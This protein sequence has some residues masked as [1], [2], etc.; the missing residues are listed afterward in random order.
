MPVLRN[1]IL[2][3]F[4]LRDLIFSISNPSTTPN[5][6]SIKY[7]AQIIGFFFFVANGST[8]LYARSSGLENIK[9][10]SSFSK[11]YLMARDSFLP[12]SFKVVLVCPWIFFFYSS[13]FGHVL[14]RLLSCF[15]LPL[16]NC[17]TRYKDYNA[18]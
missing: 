5:P 3:F 7:F 10:I 12:S 18:T 4:S 9:L 1:T 14:Q 8:V 13:R 2:C 17:N 6:L 11:A 15:P 16:K